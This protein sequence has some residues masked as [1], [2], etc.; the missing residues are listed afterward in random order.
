MSG[1]PETDGT[2]QVNKSHY[3]RYFAYIGKK[4]FNE[5]PPDI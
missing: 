2:E 5:L 1:K 3:K 4:L